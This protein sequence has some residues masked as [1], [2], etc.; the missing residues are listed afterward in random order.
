MILRKSYLQPQALNA[1]GKSLPG[2]TTL[3]YFCLWNFFFFALV[4]FCLITLIIHLL[5]L[6]SS[7]PLLDVFTVFVFIDRTFMETNPRMGT[8]MGRK[9]II[10]T[11]KLVKGLQLHVFRL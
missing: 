4:L 3:E 8:V 10:C 7:L 1:D 5:F 9:L 6:D 11:V 2:C